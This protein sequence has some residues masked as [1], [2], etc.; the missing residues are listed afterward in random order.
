MRDEELAPVCRIYLDLAIAHEQALA[1][2]GLSKSVIDAF[3]I[4]ISSYESA[5]P[6]PRNAIANRMAY[7]NKLAELYT[8]ADAILKGKIDKLSL[9]LKKAN[10]EFITAYTANRAIVNSGTTTT[11]LRIIIKDEK[12]MEPLS[13][14][15]VQI[16][17]IDFESKTGAAGEVIAKPIPQGTY[18]AQIKKEG[19]QPATLTEVKVTQGKTNTM[20]IVLK[21]SA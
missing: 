18:T 11:A 8:A 9:P 7:R 10:P 15:L 14:A 13:D 16:E 17:K 2:Y 19:Y 12:T 6:A 20:E 21:M 5:V 1:D 3:T 4:A